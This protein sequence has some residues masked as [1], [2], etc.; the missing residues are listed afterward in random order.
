MKKFE[1]WKNEIE[2]NEKIENKKKTKMKKQRNKIVASE[3]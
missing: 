2:K 3:I 1:K